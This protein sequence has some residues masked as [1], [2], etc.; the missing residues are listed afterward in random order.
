L[1]LAALAGFAGAASALSADACCG[2]SAGA[3]D[4]AASAVLVSSLWLF[5]SSALCVAESSGG[6]ASCTLEPCDTSA[7]GRLA[8]AFTSAD[9]L[10]ALFAAALAA[11]LAAAEFCRSMLCCSVRENGLAL[12]AASAAALLELVE[13]LAELLPLVPS[14][15]PICERNDIGVLSIRQRVRCR[16]SNQ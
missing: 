15:E 11:V 5:A 6:G 10:A 16:V 14:R 7:D 9:A 3:E 8:P 12:A 13:L 4:D 1:A 2:F